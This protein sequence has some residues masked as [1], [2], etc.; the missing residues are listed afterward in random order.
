MDILTLLNYSFPSIKHWCFSLLSEAHSTQPQQFSF[1]AKKKINLI[2]EVEVYFCKIYSTD[3]TTRHRW[4]SCLQ[5]I[6]KIS[7]FQEK[8]PHKNTNCL[9]W[10]IQVLQLLTFKP[11]KQHKDL[12]GC[13]VGFFPPIQFHLLAGKLYPQ[14]SGWFQ[15]RSCLYHKNP[16]AFYLFYLLA[17]KPD[18]VK[19]GKFSFKI[20]CSKS[21]Y[22]PSNK[23]FISSHWKFWIFNHDY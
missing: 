21:P 18:T 2:M 13:G 16:S 8:K 10:E 11:M 14:S 7:I 1:K 19:C 15:G 4:C 22:R 20:P 9:D 17:I 12:S 3:L 5:T 6:Q 23:A